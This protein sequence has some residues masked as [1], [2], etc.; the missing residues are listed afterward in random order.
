MVR[1]G[2]HTISTLIDCDNVDDPQTCYTTEPLIQDIEPEQLIPHKNYDSHLKVNDIGLIRLKTAAVFT[3]LGNVETICLPTKPE[4]R[5]ENL[6]KSDPESFQMTIAG[7]GY[8]EYEDKITDYLMF[9]NIGYLD[10]KN[11]SSRYAELAKNYSWI[12]TDIEDSQM[13]RKF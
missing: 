4:H 13:V 12:K 3:E 8:T 7:W 9:A 1:L 10:N 5:V 6:I 11:C 2:E